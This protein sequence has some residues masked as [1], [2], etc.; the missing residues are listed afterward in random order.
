MKI[1]IL[2]NKRQKINKF[3]NILRLEFNGVRVR[4]IIMIKILIFHYD[5]CYFS[6]INICDYTMPNFFHLDNN[7]SSREIKHSKYTQI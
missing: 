2:C 4:D 1:S 3:S 5:I 6:V 7:N